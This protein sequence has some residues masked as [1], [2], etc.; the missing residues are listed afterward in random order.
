MIQRG[1]LTG[2]ML[3]AFSFPSTPSGYVSAA[4]ET[5]A[6]QSANGPA[7]TT[8][9]AV[10]KR[11]ATVLRDRCVHCHGETADVMGEID[12]VQFLKQAGSEPEPDPE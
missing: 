7:N 12:L 1:L 10:Q 9:V 4:D 5:A 3:L 11:I 2:L 6:D 8:L